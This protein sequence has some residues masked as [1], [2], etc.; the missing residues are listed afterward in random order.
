MDYSMDKEFSGVA[1]NGLMSKWRPGM[2][3]VPQVSVLV[4]AQFNIFISVMDSGIEC[5]LSKAVDNTKLCGAVNTL[6]R[7]YAIH[8]DFDRPEKWAC[9]NLM[10]LNKAKCKVLHLSQCNTEYKHR[11]GGGGLGVGDG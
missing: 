2:S 4:A 3:G 10:K 9:V 6:E 5:T 1:V 11:Q 7:R 8:R